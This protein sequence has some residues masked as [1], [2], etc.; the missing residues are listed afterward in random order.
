MK[1]IIF[2]KIALD[3]T[4]FFLLTVFSIGIIIWVLQA[5]NF[6][7]VVIEDGHSFVVYS[8]YTLLN[9]PKILSK[10]F[11]F[12]LFIALINI[13]LRYESNNE[14]VVFWNFGIHKKKF[15]NFFIKFSFLFLIVQLFLTVFLV[16]KSQD[17]ARSYIK[18]S[19]VAL[20]E[21]LLKPRKFIDAIKDLTIF[22]DKK[23]IN[24][25]LQ[26]IFL[27]DNSSDNSFQITFAK[28]GRFEKRG[29]RKVL[30]LFEGITINNKNKQLSGF[31]FLKTDFNIS[32]FESTTT[33]TTKTQENTSKELINCILILKDVVKT[34]SNRN[35]SV[36]FNNCR[37]GN[38]Q[39]II[40]E[41]YKRAI[42]PF[43]I[44]IF[45][46]IALFL[47]IKSK[48]QDGYAGHKIKIF[49][50]G[51]A[52]IIFSEISI[53]FVNSN[54]YENILLFSLPLIFFIILYFFFTLQLKVK[55]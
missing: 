4:N 29:E 39:N 28:N 21:S 31:E 52:S 50:F 3:C 38:M 42:M 9:L 18:E 24:G 35:T 41:I 13:L 19:D 43:Y 16:P 48:D 54:I 14:L 22:V 40:Q 51:F 45:I 5:V 32:K 11:P 30:V 55:R 49:I 33:T 2:R 20:F 27:K 7:D 34:E 8:Y 17:V 1:K 23:K 53:K 25:D 36:N 47:I 26:N 10:I 6:L 44:P 37:T 12:A 15:F 46:I